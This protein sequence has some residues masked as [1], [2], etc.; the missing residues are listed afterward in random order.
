MSGRP[1]AGDARRTRFATTS[2]VALEGPCCA[3]K[4]TLARALVDC[5]ADL[6]VCSVPCYADHV[7]GGRF[8]PPP[9]P[10][11]LGEDQAGLRA[12]LMI[13]NDR[14][15][16]PRAGQYDVA[17]LDRSVHTLLAHRYAI[18]QLTGLGCYE[19]ATT[20]VSL[21]PAPAWPSLVI[22]LDVSQGAVEQRNRGKFPAD[23]LFIDARFNSAIRSYYDSVTASGDAPIVW[24]DGE[25][26]SGKLIDQ[27][28]TQI[29]ALL[30]RP[31]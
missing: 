31:D 29:R 10:I 1:S 27:A 19:S 30:R 2:Y 15:A 26:D 4:T 5:L 13:E 16:G 14:L 22:F 21:S 20:T 17:L 8:L 18:D 28:E 6:A 25:L 11:S 12:L 3:G 24:L 7:G 23:S 9:V